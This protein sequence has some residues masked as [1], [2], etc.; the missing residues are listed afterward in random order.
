LFSVYIE[1]LFPLPSNIKAVRVVARL[2]YGNETKAKQM[3]RLMSFVRNNSQ[4][5]LSQ[6]RF[7][8][9]LSF[10]DAHLCELHREAL[11]LFEIYASLSDDNDSGLISEVFDGIPMRRIGWCSQTLFDHQHCLI[12]GERYLGIIDAGTA[13]PTGFY[14]LRNVSD[15]D[16]LILTISFPNQSVI[17]PDVQARN[18]MHTKNFTDL[19]RDKQES[20]CRLLDRPSLLLVDHSIMTT[21]DNRKQQL[22]I[23]ISDEGMFG[24]FPR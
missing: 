12:T 16:C 2:C 14:S 7:D 1:S 20:L 11:M 22:L 17:W 5:S 3:T 24:R 6:V 21:T 13:N 23:N 8:Q 19:P 9:K 10:D 18:D 4:D 15:R